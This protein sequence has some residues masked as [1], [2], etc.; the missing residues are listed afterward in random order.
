[1]IIISILVIITHTHRMRGGGCNEGNLRLMGVR[2]AAKTMQCHTTRQ[3]PT[4]TLCVTTFQISIHDDAFFKP[5]GNTL[6]LAKIGRMHTS[7]MAWLTSSTSTSS[8]SNRI[9]FFALV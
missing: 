3:I 4:I 2:A 9:P 1:M 8:T 7:K 5:T 6:L